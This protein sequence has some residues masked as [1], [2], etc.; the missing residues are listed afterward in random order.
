M[1]TF[2]NIYL[3]KIYYKKCMKYWGNCKYNKKKFKIFHL[4]IPLYE[5]MFFGQKDP[6]KDNSINA[7]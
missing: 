1:Y 7:K 3:F 4:Q 2:K 6:K 5:N